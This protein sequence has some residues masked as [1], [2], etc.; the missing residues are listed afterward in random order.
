MEVNSRLIISEL[1]LREVRATITH[2]YTK[3]PVN[4]AE[5]TTVEI[6]LA[7]FKRRFKSSRL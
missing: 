3:C 1:S 6:E 7:Y 5:Q 4:T 2:V